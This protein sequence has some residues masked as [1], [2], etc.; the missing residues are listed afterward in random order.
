MKKGIWFSWFLKT[1][2]VCAT[3]NDRNERQDYTGIFSTQIVNVSHE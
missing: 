2:T 1:P 3:S